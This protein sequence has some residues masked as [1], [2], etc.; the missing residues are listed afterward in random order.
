MHGDLKEYD[1]I[2]LVYQSSNSLTARSAPPYLGQF[3]DAPIGG[4]QLALGEQKI[5]GGACL[6]GDG[7]RRAR[8]GRGRLLMMRR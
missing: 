2:V 8:V 4:G 1:I 6:T 3:R 7:L 5:C